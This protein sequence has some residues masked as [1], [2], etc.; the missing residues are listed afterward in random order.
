MFDI[1]SD[2]RSEIF[3]SL[4]RTRSPFRTA[5]DTGYNI[6]MVLQVH[7][8]ESGPKSSYEERHGGFGPQEKRQFSVAR[9]KAWA[10]WDN[11]LPEVARARQAYEEGT[12][13]LATGRDGDYTILYAFPRKHITPRPGYFNPIEY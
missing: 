1:P 9:K 5:K 7:E 2:I 13:E 4:L 11:N 8:E 12:V 10:S 3:R 6:R